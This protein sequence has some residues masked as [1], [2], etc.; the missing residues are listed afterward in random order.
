MLSRSVSKRVCFAPVR[1]GLSHVIAWSSD[2]VVEWSSSHVVAWLCEAL[3][4]GNIDLETAVEL[5]GGIVPAANYATAGF[6]EVKGTWGKMTVG[7]G[8]HQ[9]G[10]GASCEP[11][12]EVVGST[13]L[14]PQEH[15]YRA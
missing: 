6:E 12:S 4:A 1:G 2:R 8:R 11:R 9:A 14:V 13:G 5:F 7:Q 3:L 15:A 10:A